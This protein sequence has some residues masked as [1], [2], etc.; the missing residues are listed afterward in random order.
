MTLDNTKLMPALF[1]GHGSPL[2]IT[3]DNPFTPEWENIAKK[4]S[5]PKAI[6]VISAHWIRDEREITSNEKQKQI[7]DFYGF[8]DE[9][10]RVKYETVGSPELA[11]QIQN[12]LGEAKLAKCWGLD[13]GAW[14]VLS[15]MYPSQDIP[16]IQISLRRNDTVADLIELGKKL[17]VLRSKGVLVLG[18]GNIVHN[19]RLI[20]FNRNAETPAWAEEFDVLVK[21]IV[22]DRDLPAL[23]KLIEN[24]ESIEKAHPSLEHIFPLIPILAMADQD[25]QI[26]IFNSA[27]DLSS[28]SM[29]S[30]SVGL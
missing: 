29:T 8:P 15:K 1:I 11:E 23:K 10:Y 19:L 16:V 17:K 22:R 28:I 4:I 27:F 9:L 13:H 30:F 3:Q 6:V 24:H 18:S 7:F 25:D 12:I 21:D 5:K 2:L 14:C 20:N 26:N